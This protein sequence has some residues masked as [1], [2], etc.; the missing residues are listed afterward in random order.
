MDNL[1][2][3]NAGDASRQQLSILAERARLT[4]LVADLQAAVA[5]MEAERKGF[6]DAGI[7]RVLDA[8]IG[9]ASLTLDAAVKR[10][11]SLDVAVGGTEVPAPRVEYPP[12]S[13]EKVLAGH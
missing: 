7:L 1:H 2:A 12:F 9:A 6:T 5:F 13:Q 8:L 11:A 3:C 4:D 10:C